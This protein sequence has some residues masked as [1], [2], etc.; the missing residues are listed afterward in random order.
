MAFHVDLVR[1]DWLAGIQYPLATFKLEDGSGEVTLDAAQPELWQGVLEELNGQG[2]VRQALAD[3]HTKLHGS[4][5]F[6]TE[7]HA[8]ADC[9]FH[10]PVYLQGEEA[11]GS[12][13]ALPAGA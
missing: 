8:V 11:S 3:L 1:N 6:A 13:S 9:P 10:G 7:G 2:D 12:A 4:H 5:L